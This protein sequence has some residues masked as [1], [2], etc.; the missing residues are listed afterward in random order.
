M[1]GNSEP[2]SNWAGINGLS[3]GCVKLR[4][5][6]GCVR[7]VQWV[8]VNRLFILQELGLNECIRPTTKFPRTCEDK[9]LV[10]IIKI[11][12]KKKKRHK[13]NYHTCLLFN[14]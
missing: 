10:S 4:F 2:L 5:L 12:K 7:F 8:L 11:Q 14:I 9:I 13:N 1:L 3:L 6:L